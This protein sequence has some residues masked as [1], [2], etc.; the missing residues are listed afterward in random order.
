[1]QAPTRSHCDV[2]Y[3]IHQGIVKLTRRLYDITSYDYQ[4]IVYLCELM[5][6]FIQKQL[7]A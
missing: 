2:I 4:G 6:I 7:E 5:E 1:M 3:C